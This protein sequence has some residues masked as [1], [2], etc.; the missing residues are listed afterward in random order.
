MSRILLVIR[1]SCMKL[2]VLESPH[3][4]PQTAAHDY[5]S[6]SMQVALLSN[7]RNFKDMTAFQLCVINTIPII[8]DSQAYATS[9][10]YLPFSILPPSRRAR[11]CGC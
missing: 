5:L 4:S 7:K 10:Q 2:Q 8:H 9:P 1:I 6:F 11:R 3:C